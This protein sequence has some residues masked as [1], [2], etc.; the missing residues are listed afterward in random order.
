MDRR[1]KLLS[2]NIVVTRPQH[3]TQHIRS[4]LEVEG[5]SVLSCPCIEIVP[6]HTTASNCAKIAALDRYQLVVFISQNAV[7]HGLALLEKTST[8]LTQL[9]PVAAIG[10]STCAL[11]QSHGISVAV[12][13]DSANS[14]ALT[15]TSAVQALP[16]HSRVLI[17]RGQG[18]K[19]TL[20]QVL[21]Q[22]NI[23]CE[24]AE[25]YQRVVPA[26]LQIPSGM[27]NGDTFDIILF[28][29]RD[30]FVNFFNATT[31]PMPRQLTKAHWIL[32]SS[33]LLEVC[34]Q[35]KLEPDT[36]PTIAQSPLDQDMFNAVLAWREK[37][38]IYNYNRET[39]KK[40]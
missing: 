35:M 33:A 31:T 21:G 39:V 24:Y 32:G 37:T 1:P 17:F 12:C 25:V 18:G 22:K 27:P 38:Q 4:L 30:I 34:T 20:A 23:V 6:M 9:P 14:I 7:E 36:P 10:K 3:Q 26:S 11:L 16:A 19:E 5:A 2:T 28:T 40:Q 29:S 15:Q 8:P 13:P